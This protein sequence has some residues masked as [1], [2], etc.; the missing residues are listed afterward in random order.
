MASYEYICERINLPPEQIQMAQM[1]A[2]EEKAM[3]D[4]DGLIIELLNEK[5]KEGWE[6]LAPISFPT[7]FFR[8]VKEAK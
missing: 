6:V 2:L 8:R 5:G 7:V 1:G 3:K 4:I